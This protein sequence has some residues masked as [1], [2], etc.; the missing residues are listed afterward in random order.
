VVVIN[1]ISKL[2]KVKDALL[3]EGIKVYGGEDAVA[4]VVQMESVDMVLASIVRYAGLKSTLAAIKAG[5]QIALA[6][7]ETLVVAGELVTKTAREHAVNLYPVDSEHS[8]IF[9]CLPAELENPIEKIYPTASRGPFR[10]KPPPA[11]TSVTKAQP[12]KH[13]NETFTNKIPTAP[14]SYVA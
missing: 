6:N 14:P 3:D 11:F 4:D 7:K 9:Q 1:D 5:K 8:A 13:P 12:P 10:H 2:A